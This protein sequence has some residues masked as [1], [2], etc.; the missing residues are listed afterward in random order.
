MC[1]N[2]LSA[3]APKSSK[4]TNALKQIAQKNHP[5]FF[6]AAS[7]TTHENTNDRIFTRYAKFAPVLAQIRASEKI[8]F[9]TPIPC[10]F[11][12]QNHAQMRIPTDKTS[13]DNNV[14]YK[15]MNWNKV[16]CSTCGF[17]EIFWETET[18]YATGEL[19]TKIAREETTKSARDV[20]CGHAE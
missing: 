11:S 17:Y 5:K 13:E 14:L 10:N 16:S 12:I 6:S 15:N 4:I 18:H 8:D 3:M 1:S 9:N 7:G 2:T 20:K 19:E